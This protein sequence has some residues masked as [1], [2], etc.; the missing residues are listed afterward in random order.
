MK[1]T[2][3]KAYIERTANQNNSKKEYLEVLED[4]KNKLFNEICVSAKASNNPLH[5]VGRS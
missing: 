2:Q 3:L 5:A 4:E 1:P